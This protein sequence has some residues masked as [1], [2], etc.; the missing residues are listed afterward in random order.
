M[1]LFKYFFLLIVFITSCGGPKDDSDRL[2]IGYVV[3]FMSHEWYQNICRAA[4]KHAKK[5]GVDLIIADANMDVAAQIS[6]AENLL[7]QGVD[8]LVLTPVDSKAMGNIVS[9]AKESGVRVITESNPVS[10]SDTYVGIDNEASGFKAGKWFAEYA[11]SQSISPKILIIG[12]PNFDDCRKRVE[13]FKRGLVE[14]DISYEIIQEV[15]GQGLKEKAFKVAQDALT[16]NPNINAI[17]GINDDSVS[18]GIS[19]YKAANLNEKKLTAIGFGFEGTV[20]QTALMGDTPYRS[21]LAM[22]PDFV[23]VSLVDAS[24]RLFANEKVPD[25]Y[26]TPTIMITRE[27]V[28]RFYDTKT[29]PFT[30]KLDNVRVLLQ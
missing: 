10:G 7:A 4:E 3:N 9:Q 15:D 20:G 2:K 24:I 22:F 8:V 13:G 30:M 16:A 1:S 27:N 29:D 25:H 28:D 19:A 17:F 5:M 26:E 14:S 6:K 12:Y 18:G 21:A 23:G 11:T